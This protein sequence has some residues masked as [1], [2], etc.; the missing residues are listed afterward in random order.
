[1]IVVTLFYLLLGGVGIFL[2]QIVM[3]RSVESEIRTIER[4]ALFL[5]RGEGDVAA[6]GRGIARR[7]LVQCVVFVAQMTTAPSTEVLRIVVKYYHLERYLVNHILSSRSSSDRAYMLSQL[8]RL[9]ISINTARAVE[10]L[11]ED[12]DADVSFYALMTLFAAAPN[13]AVIRVANME[14]KLSRREVAEILSML[15]RGCCPIPYTPL[16]M[17]DNYNLQL[18]GIHLVRR[19]GIVESRGEIICILRDRESELREDALTT[20]ATFG[21]MIQDNEHYKYHIV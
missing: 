13:M 15:S 10:Y 12:S 16:L 3:R 7:R 18:L 5:A 21:E 20:L 6:I 11:I 8:A 17:S 2:Y 19:F 4:L 9:P 14:H 1:M